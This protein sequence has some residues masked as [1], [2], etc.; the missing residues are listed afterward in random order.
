MTKLT[1]PSPLLVFLLLLLTACGGVSKNADN[2]P[3]VVGQGSAPPSPPPPP[4]AAVS[5]EDAP[6]PIASDDAVLGSRL[7]PA[8]IVV[9]SDLQCPYCAKLDLTFSM[10]K[11]Q[12]GDDRLRIVFKNNPLPFH[13]HARL[14]AEVGQ[15]VLATAGQEAFWRYAMMA[16]RRQPNMSPET[17]RAWAVAAG[18]DP[19]QIEEGIES[20][21]WSAKIERDIALSKRLKANGTPTSFING[22][23]VTGAQ[24]GARFKEVIDAE[25]AKAKTL[26]EA[27][28]AKDA[29][30]TQLTEANFHPRNE[31]EETI[32]RA[33]AES[34][35]IHRVPVVA[36]QQ[37]VRGPAH[38]QVTIVMFSDFECP[39]C[40]RAQATLTKIRNDYGDKVRVVW[41]DM[42]LSSHSRAEPAAELARAARAQKGDAGFWTVHDLLFD[43]QPALADADLE[44]IAK[45][46]KLDVGRAMA[47]VK[48]RQFK[49]QIED[50]IEVGDDFDTGGAPHFFINGRRVYGAKAYETVFKPILDE[51]VKKADAL[52][53]N[54]IALKD[55]YAELTKTGQMPLPLEKKSIAPPAASAPYRGAPNAKIVVQEVADFQCPFC[56]RADGSIDQLLKDYPGKIKVVW[57]DKPLPNHPDAPLAAEAAREAFVQRGA[58]GFQKMAKLLLDNQRALKRD[59]LDGYAKTVGL[60]MMKFGFS[61]DNR[62]HQSSID[63]DARAAEDAGV[64]GTPAFF[65]G[66]Y[67]ISGAQPYSRFRKAVEQILNPP[68]APL[69]NVVMSSRAQALLAAGAVVA[70]MPPG[71]IV[72]EMAV[73]SGAATA[74]RGDKLKVH[75]TGTLTDGSE[76]DSSRTRGQPFTFEAGKGAV[77]KGWDAGLIGMKVG[78]KRKLTIP[79]DLAYGD[80]G[81]P[82][83]IPPNATLIFDVE[84]L[85]IE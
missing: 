77:I 56:K 84:L 12:Y 67:F 46:A 18:A 75:Y 68:P 64:S 16:F 43:A 4:Q 35:A 38:A 1:F 29:I 8:T 7:A 82:P 47:A 63:A 48:S 27:G 15:G 39:F 81:A 66:P 72:K 32:A 55:V 52:L 30:Y 53:M 54:G 74:K 60:D 62:V 25:V 9:F 73:G 37:P 26:L 28:V 34:R 51:E 80:R 85:A 41:R 13:P 45:E 10:L 50:D 2:K 14:A 59:D 65:V 83:K 76:F 17:I 44:R 36:S 6:V 58:E 49:K 19:R 20:M 70:G 79:P 42:P 5:E 22:V 71:L 3:L 69:P 57:R 33:L 61:L 21:R 31:E 24:D 78:G 23:S 40:K 11:E